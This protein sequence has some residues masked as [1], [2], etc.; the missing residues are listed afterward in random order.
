MTK[1]QIAETMTK[2]YKFHG[3][4]ND[5]VMLDGRDYPDIPSTSDIAYLCHRNFGIGADGLI[6]VAPRAGYDFE[7]IYFNSDGSPAMMCGNGARCAVAF[8]SLIGMCGNNTVFL[9][10][11]GR[12]TA[13]LTHENE[14]DSMVRI[15]MRD[16]DIPSE[17]GSLTEIN[18]GTPHLVNIVPTT[19]EVDVFAEGRKIR[20]SSRYS[21][22]GIN[23][24]WLSIDNNVLNVRTYERGVENETLSC[25]TGVTACAVVASLITG[26][27][28]WKVITRGG[29][30]WVEMKKEESRFSQITLKGPVQ[31]VYTGEI[32]IP[33][34]KGDITSVLNPDINKIKRF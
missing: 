27:T 9:A 20:Y 19:D 24:D 23:V 3:T 33:V 29:T 26:Q 34:I 5:F 25:G 16:T 22:N 7:M 1:C 6:L 31:L 32:S 15:S 17:Y 11:D 18:T 8:A 13:E 14:F 10:G 30:L 12:H 2:F 4:G 28:N 21:D